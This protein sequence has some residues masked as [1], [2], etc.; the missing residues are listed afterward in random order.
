MKGSTAAIGNMPPRIIWEPDNKEMILISGGEFLMGRDD[1]QDDERPAHTVYVLPFYIDRYPVTQQEYHRFVQATDHPIPRY[2]VEWVDSSAYNWD[3]DTRT[4]PPD[5]LD[6]P[7]VLVTWGDALAYSQWAQKRLPT[8][9]EWERAARGTDGRRWPWGDKLKEENCNTRYL[10]LGQ[11][12]PVHQFSPQ[13]DTPEG[14]GDL[15]GNTWEWTGSLYRPYPFDEND[16]RQD[17][18]APGWRVLRGGSWLNDFS[19]A[20]STTRLDGDFLFYTN[21]GFRCAI[22]VSVVQDALYAAFID[23]CQSSS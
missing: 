7:V 15:I 17:P 14:V 23:E 19:Q 9:A 4:P 20:N 12:T 1:G 5:K 8:E 2:D 10:D 16:G 3:S 11:T 6:H 21:V 13:S 18:S 22:S